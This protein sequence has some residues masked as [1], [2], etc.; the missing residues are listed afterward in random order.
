MPIL[1][2]L[3]EDYVSEGSAFSD[4]VRVVDL[5]KPR[6]EFIP[7][8]TKKSQ[9]Y[10]HSID[11][12]SITGD[13]SGSDKYCLGGLINVN[14]TP[15]PIMITSFIRTPNH[16]IQVCKSGWLVAYLV[17]PEYV[18]HEWVTWFSKVMIHIFSSMID[19]SFIFSY[20]VLDNE[21]YYDRETMGRCVVASW[22]GTGVKTKK[23][24]IKPMKYD[25]IVIKD[26]VIDNKCVQ[27]IQIKDVFQTDATIPNDR[28]KYH[29]DK[30]KKHK[31][32]RDEK[33]RLSNQ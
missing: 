1:Q 2:L 19:D 5:Y 9:S 4:D 10:T 16:A 26:Y 7:D 13:I 18:G 14:G 22:D 28:K 17:N 12:S 33:I 24:K 27:V 21:G 11:Y 30:I 15:T 6:P 29:K 3:D 8:W 32:K 25:M 20:I 23:Q 31:D